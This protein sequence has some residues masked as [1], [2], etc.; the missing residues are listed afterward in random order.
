MEAARF[1]VSPS[2]CIAQQGDFAG[3]A[4]VALKVFVDS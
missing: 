4:E 2:R 3:K 1:E